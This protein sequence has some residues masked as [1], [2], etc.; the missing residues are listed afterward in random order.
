MKNNKSN[1][2]FVDGTAIAEIGKSKEREL[3]K[4]I[5]TEEV[6]IMRIVQLCLTGK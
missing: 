2:I 4:S 5:F 6:R 1:I 3:M